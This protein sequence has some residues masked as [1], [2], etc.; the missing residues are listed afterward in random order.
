MTW[1]N[2]G[3]APAYNPFQLR[4]RLCGPDTLNAEIPSG[5]HKWLPVPGGKTY[6]EAYRIE[7]PDHLKPG[8]Y[9]LQLKLYSPAADRDV[10]LP[11]KQNLRSADGFYTLAKVRVE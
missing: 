10:L 9:S 8:E 1:E 7:L 2:R 11:L 4:L 3:V 5:N 6:D